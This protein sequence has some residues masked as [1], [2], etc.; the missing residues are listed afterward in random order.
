MRNLSLS[1]KG[2]DVRSWKYFLIGQGLFVEVDENFDLETEN[3]TKEFQKLHNIKPDGIVGP[4]TLKVAKE[5]GFYLMDDTESELP[6]EPDFKPLS[7]NER[8]KI[9]GSFGFKPAPTPQNPEGII[10]TDNWVKTNIVNTTIPQLSKI[11]GAPSNQTIQCHVLAAEKIQQ[12]FEAWE[13]EDLI[14]KILTWDGCWV[15]RFVRGSKSTLSNHSFGTAFDINARWNGLGV[16]PP[17]A[18][19][20]GSLVELVGIA[21]EL[22]FWW[23]G[24]W[25][26]TPGSRIDPMHFELVKIA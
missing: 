21:N 7:Y 4:Y 19:K 25:G 8:F 15:P 12:L 9:F 1:S 23:G 5:N 16:N 18:S 10:I 22:G 11:K 6:P 2:E 14:Q 13:Q 26:K 17:P 20:T 3:Q 24:H